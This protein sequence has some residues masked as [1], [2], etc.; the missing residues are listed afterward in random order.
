[1]AEG[2]PVVIND[3]VKKEK[4]VHIAHNRKARQHTLKYRDG[5]FKIDKY[6]VL[7]SIN[8]SLTR[9]YNNTDAISTDV[10]H[11]KSHYACQASA[12]NNCQRQTTR[13]GEPL[14]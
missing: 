12:A 4:L 1:M 14:V 11:D 5:A 9:K 3:T 6:R 7:Q 8:P 2:Y 13:M 10:T